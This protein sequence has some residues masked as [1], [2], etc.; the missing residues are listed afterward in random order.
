[1]FFIVFSGKRMHYPMGDFTSTRPVSEATLFVG[2]NK[3]IESLRDNTRSTVF[4]GEARI[5]KTSLLFQLKRELESVGRKLIPRLPLYL[6][7][8]NPRFK[9]PKDVYQAIASYVAGELRKRGVLQV[10]ELRGVKS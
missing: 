10:P 3:I 4:I 9:E 8:R 5:G 6:N 1:M 7:L 2:R